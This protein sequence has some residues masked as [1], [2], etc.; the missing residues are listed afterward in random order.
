MFIT[1]RQHEREIQYL[2]NEINSVSNRVWDLYKKYNALLNHVNLEEY[3]IVA[4]IAY[5]EKEKL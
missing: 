3:E 5:R 4:Q 2:R 1:K